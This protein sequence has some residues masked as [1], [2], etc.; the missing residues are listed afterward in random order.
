MKKI[1]LLLML[2]VLAAPAFAEDEPFSRSFDVSEYKPTE[3]DFVK[4]TLRG[5]F[6]RNWKI[7]SYE[8]GKINASYRDDYKIVISFNGKQVTIAQAAD[9]KEI[10]EKW[11][12]ALEDWI[13]QEMTY[14]YYVKK[15]EKM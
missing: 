4:S 6:A 2:F 1:A 3:V 12:N 11:G 7:E 13:K 8:K 15:A 9:S 14:L 10:R 5:M